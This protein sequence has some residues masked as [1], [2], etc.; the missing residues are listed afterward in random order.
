MY[1]KLEKHL[2]IICGALFVVE[3][4]LDIIAKI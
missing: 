2:Y 4:I 3:K 1:E